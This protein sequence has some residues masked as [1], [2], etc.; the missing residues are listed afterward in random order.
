MPVSD[1]NPVLWTETIWSSKWV[2]KF[3]INISPAPSGFHAVC[4][5]KP[6]LHNDKL[7]MHS[8]TALAGN[9]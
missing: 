7:R 8:A 2:P 3:S 5:H 6:H 1:Y 4:S 9:H